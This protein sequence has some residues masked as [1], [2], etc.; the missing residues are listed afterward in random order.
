LFRVNLS[1]STTSY[2]STFTIKKDGTYDF[3]AQTNQDFKAL[4]KGLV[5][6][7]ALIQTDDMKADFG[8]YKKFNEELDRAIE[9]TY[10][11]LG[12]KEN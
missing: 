6:L 4:Q 9:F 12:N 8:Q 10:F 7:R 1:T 11:V 5:E 3:E 2:K